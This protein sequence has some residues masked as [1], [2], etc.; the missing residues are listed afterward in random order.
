MY[1][2]DKS[3]LLLDELVPE[4]L[5][6]IDAE[7]DYLRQEVDAQYENL[8]EILKLLI[9]YQIVHPKREKFE[10]EDEDALAQTHKE[11]KKLSK[12]I[13]E[14]QEFRRNLE[15]HQASLLERAV[16]AIEGYLPQEAPATDA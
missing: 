10:R 7:L 6:E 14:K 9:A 12:L 3:K 1:K 11:I 4:L 15:E 2:L 16:Q 5:A 13:A 8:R